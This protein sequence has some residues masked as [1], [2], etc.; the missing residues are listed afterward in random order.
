MVCARGRKL[1]GGRGCAGG[2]GLRGFLLLPQ[3]HSVGVWVV[4][5]L[6]ADW[7]EIPRGLLGVCSETTDVLKL[8]PI[9]KLSSIKILKRNIIFSFFFNFFLEHTILRE[10]EL[11]EL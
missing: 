8:N 6:I 10:V 2:G 4:E 11:T 1:W 5:T 3:H 7:E 9:L